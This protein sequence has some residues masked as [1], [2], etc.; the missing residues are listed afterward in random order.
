[1]FFE[2]DAKGSGIIDFRSISDYFRKNSNLIYDQEIIL[3]LHRL[4]SDGDGRLTL[5]NLIDFLSL[6]QPMEKTRNSDI[7][8]VDNIILNKIQEEACNVLKSTNLSNDQ[9]NNIQKIIVNETPKKKAYPIYDYYPF[10]SVR[11]SNYSPGTLNTPSKTSA[12]VENFANLYKS[13][14]FWS[15]NDNTNG[16]M[17][18]NIQ[19]SRND[20]YPCNLVRK[21]YNSQVSYNTPCKTEED[22][23]NYANFDK[24]GKF[25]YNDDNTGLM[26]SNIQK[27]QFND[28]NKNQKDREEFISK[29]KEKPEKITYRCTVTG[30]GVIIPLEKST[31]K[32]KS[33]ANSTE[34]EKVKDDATIKAIIHDAEQR[35][36]FFKEINENWLKATKDVKIPNIYK[37]PDFVKIVVKYLLKLAK[38]HDK[39]EE[40]KMDLVKQRDFN[41]IDFFGFFDVDRKGF[42]TFTEFS[43]FLKEQEMEIDLEAL[44]VLIKRFDRKNT[45]KMRFVDFE[46]LLTTPGYKGE[47]RKPLNIG[48]F[49]FQYTEVGFILC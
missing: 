31:K 24:S 6:S 42:C 22:F 14:K 46:R 36:N 45:Q 3:I 16:L 20:Y 18:S 47:Y 1:M 28:C 25:C 32:N 48:G 15:N 23:D 41:L 30:S 38:S 13:A 19:Q 12:E 34:I 40:I 44:G 35:N 9:Q 4:D 7:F 29:M 17:S 49:Q 43:H 11:K 8:A 33:I 2:I 5:D 39:L 10:K 21:S 37:T 27:S 26:N